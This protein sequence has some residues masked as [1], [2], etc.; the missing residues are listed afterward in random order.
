MKQQWGDF[1]DGWSGGVWDVLGGCGQRG[2]F[3]VQFDSGDEVGEFRV[4]GDGRV[5][6]AVGRCRA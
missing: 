5:L 3:I 1:L 2:S 6:G 4:K